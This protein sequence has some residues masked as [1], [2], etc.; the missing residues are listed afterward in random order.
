MGIGLSRDKVEPELRNFQMSGSEESAG[1]E[2]KFKNRS[3][4]DVCFLIAL[5]LFLT[6][7]I[8][9]LGYCMLNGSIYR[10]INGYD[11][12]GNICGKLNNFNDKKEI[13]AECY[14]KS[15]I[16]EPYHIVLRQNSTKEINRM[17]ISNCNKYDGYRKFFNRC[18]PTKTQTVVNTLFSKTGL[19]NFFT[20][21][22]ED[23]Q[24]CWTEICYLCL[25]A[26]ALSIIL[27]ILFR[28]L[29]GLVVWIVLLGS[30][31]VSIIGTVVLWVLWRNSKSNHDNTPSY[32]IPD[33]DTET[34]HTYLVF[35]IL[36]TI[37]TVI[38]CLIIF[39]MRNRI[40]LVVQLFEESGKAIAA[41]PVLL[42]EPVLTFLFLAITVS[43]WF[44][45]CLWIESAGRL[46]ETQPNLYQYKKDGWMKF[47]RW[48]NFF[49]MLWM[50]QFAIGCQHMI[51]AGAVG[52]WY[53]KRNKSALG[54]PVL[55]SAEN[56]IRYHMGSVALGSFLI[57][58]VQF[59]RLLL[60][61]V[62]K[63]LKKREGKCAECM[64]KC[65]NCCLYCF[66]K[67][68]K[69]ISRNAYIQVAT[70]GY[71]FCKGGQQAFKLLS[72]NVLRVAAINSVGDFVLFL[73]K[74]VVVIATVLIG[75]KMLQYKDGLQHMW[76]PVT[77]AGLFAY[78]VAHCF[79]TVYEM[80]IDTVFLCFCEDC[81]HNDGESR[82]Y[83]MSRGLM[84]F[85]ENSKR[86]LD[87]R[88]KRPDQ[89]EADKN[90]P[91]ISG[92]MMK[93]FSG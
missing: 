64:L 79:M 44:Y 6:T 18:I 89:T 51:I 81:E 2:S 39:V 56:L 48:Y 68:L 78:F 57:A 60:K 8:C 73:G 50:A 25:I 31:A 77:L 37:A 65:C 69:Y 33:V 16:N 52:I 28:Y 3:S 66:E 24:I 76:V 70:H 86:T 55:Q 32:L 43:L 21:V 1:E 53:F 4:T 82:P 74:V 62:E 23:F 87:K 58:L 83:H 93:N 45:F 67:I 49:A 71:P 88:S 15:K 11:N 20:E 29:V 40:K 80:A 75:I 10:V 34:S 46:T 14:G 91:S 59:A 84:E 54:T 47:T 85:V 36:S 38:I 26:L 22:S 35:A 9:F 42:F 63:Y 90:V 72:S 17:C 19:K 27:L 13:G 30:V 5:L 92:D 41:M 61:F 12:C 7:L